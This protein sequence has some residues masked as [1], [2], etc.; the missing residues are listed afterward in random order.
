MQ[1]YLRVDLVWNIPLPTILVDKQGNRHIFLFQKQDQD[2]KDKNNQ[3][4]EKNEKNQKYQ[5]N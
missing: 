5:K 1:I 3:K 4:N 2:Q